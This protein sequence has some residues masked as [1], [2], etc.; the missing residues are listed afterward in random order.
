[1]LHQGY[2][3]LC[4]GG[5][6]GGGRR[7]SACAMCVRL[8]VCVCLGCDVGT[9]FLCQ[10]FRPGS[11]LDGSQG[12]RGPGQV[13]GE[14]AAKQRETRDRREPIMGGSERTNAGPEDV[15]Q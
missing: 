6:G 8:C 1:M 14:E 7:V 13:D 12:A 15:R 5:T 10:Q 11:E 4:R 9:A 3:I 2:V